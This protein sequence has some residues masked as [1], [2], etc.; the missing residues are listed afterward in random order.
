MIRKNLMQKMAGAILIGLTVCSFLGCS[1]E[2][3]DQ[4]TAPIATC[5]STE[6]AILI[7][8]NHGH[9][10]TVSKADIAAGTEKRYNIKGTANHTQYITLTPNEFNMLRSTATVSVTSTA[11]EAGE[12]IMHWHTVLVSC[13]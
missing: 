3:E 8:N 2:G 13:E 7:S 1:S 10:M 6:M 11:T 12:N 4:N 5:E 9:T